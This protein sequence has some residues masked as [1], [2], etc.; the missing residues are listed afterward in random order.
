[1]IFLSFNRSSIFWSSIFFRKNSSL[2]VEHLLSLWDRSIIVEIFVVNP[3]YILIAFLKT[4]LYYGK[5]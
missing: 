4:L 2:I 1:M 3:Y 5:M